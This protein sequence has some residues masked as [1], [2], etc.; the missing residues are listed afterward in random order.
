[1]GCRQVILSWREIPMKKW[2]ASLAVVASTALLATAFAGDGGAAL[3]PDDIASLDEHAARDPAA[4]N[5]Q[6]AAVGE[7]GNLVFVDATSLRSEPSADFG[8][9][10]AAAAVPSCL[11]PR[12][13]EHGMFVAEGL[14]RVP[15]LVG[16]A[17]DGACR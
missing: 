15:F 6:F 14:L 16:A 12:A 1:M 8:R 4:A 13:L 5:P 2:F 7:P 9:G 11:D 3:V 17:A 10:V